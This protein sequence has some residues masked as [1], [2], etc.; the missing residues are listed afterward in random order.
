MMKRLNLLLAMAT[1]FGSS[2]VMAAEEGGHHAAAGGIPSSLWLYVI[3]FILFIGLMFFLL[4]KPIKTAFASKIETYEAAVRR[5]EKARQDAEA[6]RLEIEQRLVQLQANA[7]KSIESARV[8]A[9]KIA[10]QLNADAQE[11]S[12]RLR[13]EAGK[14]ARAEVERAKQ[15]LQDEMLTQALALSKKLLE[16]KIVEGDQKRLQTES[17]DKITKDSAGALS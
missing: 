11:L 14:S 6:K 10:D 16:E 3:N 5:G 7:N 12:R 17:V 2:V 4:R 15:E 13:D 8:E 1:V 9:K